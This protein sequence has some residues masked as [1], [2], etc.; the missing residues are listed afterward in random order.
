VVG[1]LGALLTILFSVND[2]RAREKNHARKHHRREKNSYASHGCT[3]LVLRAKSPPGQ[4]RASAP[5]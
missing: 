1:L 5:V 3:L 4:A 2:S